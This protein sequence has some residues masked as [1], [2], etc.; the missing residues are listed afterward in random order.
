MS[1]P[2][3]HSARQLARLLGVAPRTVLNW[4]SRGLIPS[5]RITEKV[6]R[7]DWDEVVRALRGSDPRK[8]R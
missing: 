4:A 1:H 5:I 8:T 2:E 6:V 3:L 7:F